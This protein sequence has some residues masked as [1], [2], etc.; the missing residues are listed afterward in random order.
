[1]ARAT[2][3]AQKLREYGVNVVEIDGWTTRGSTTFSPK[4]VVVHHTVGGA[5][6]APSLAICINGRLDLPGPLC[7]IL[8]G[9]SGTAYVIAAGR[10]NH[11]GTGS[12]QGISGN[13]N[14]FGI[15][16]ENRGYA[17]DPWPQVQLDAYYKICKALIDGIEVGADRVCG[18][19]EWAP[20]RKVDPH[21]LDM[22]EF[23]NSVANAGGTAPAPAPAPEPAPNTPDDG[24]WR[25]GDTGDKVREIQNNCNF[26]GWDAGAVDGIFGPATEAAVKRMQSI[27]KIPA[28][29]IWGPQTEAAYHAFVYAMIEW[30]K[31]QRPTLRRGDRGE[32]VKTAQRALGGLV[33]DGIFGN[34]THARTVRVQRLKGLVADGII[35]PKTWN[36]I[37]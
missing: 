24:L 22:N 16:A 23:R 19:K 9:R 11:A 5:G 13:S 12:W 33:A 31:Q 34:A 27:L 21:T 17:S 20:G 6:E 30:N 4:G 28:D 37:L 10:A 14:M 1:M 25:L 32:W 26:W 8:L 2:W 15:E 36:A 7:N 29:G 35:G 18:H 3:I